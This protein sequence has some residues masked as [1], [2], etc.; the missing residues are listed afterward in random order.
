MRPDRFAGLRVDGPELATP[1]GE[2]GDTPNNGRRRRHVTG[3]GECPRGLQI[4]N[5]GRIDC[6]LG[7]GATRVLIVLP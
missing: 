3:G 6:V 1:I 2:V 4:A 7:R 5:V